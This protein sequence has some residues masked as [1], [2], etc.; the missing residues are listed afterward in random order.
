M[1]AHP[2]SNSSSGR[3]TGIRTDRLTR[4]FGRNFAV[5]DV[6]L[7]IRQG[8][9]FGL[10][11]PNGAGKTTLFSMLSTQ[12]PPTSGGMWIHGVNVTQNPKK[13]RRMIGI[14]PQTAAAYE[15]LTGWENLILFAELY[16]LSASEA[17]RRSHELL[18]M[19][20][21]HE[22]RH[23]FVA[24]YSGGMRHRLNI[25]LGLV[26]DPEVV[27][28]DEP[29]TGLDPIARQG[30]WDIIRLLQKAGKTLVLTTH[31]MQEAESL[32]DRVAILNKGRVVLLGEP[33]KLGKTLEEAYFRCT[34]SDDPTPK[35]DAR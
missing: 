14:V 3:S 29:T 30:L 9:L 27:F 1:A 20:G 17:R 18:R 26:H 13:I 22:R 34:T 4:R 8:E 32:C 5:H 23:D 6:S 15:K 33:S 10:L 7:D 28:F 35:R 11:G 31:Y 25:V 2:P 16:G 21:L 12:L 24:T 19:V